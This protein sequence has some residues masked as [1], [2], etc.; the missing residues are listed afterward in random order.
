MEVIIINKA[1]NKQS[2]RIIKIMNR[3]KNNQLIMN[4]IKNNHKT[5]NNNIILLYYKRII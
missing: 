3:N 5:R 1:K 4:R 2:N